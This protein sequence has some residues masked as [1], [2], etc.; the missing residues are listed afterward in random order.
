MAIL[1]KPTS[2]FSVSDRTLKYIQYSSGVVFSTFL[3]I[4]LLNTFSANLGPL[5]YDELQRLLERY[6]QN[7]FLEPFVVFGS[8]GVHI[9]S[10]VWRWFK[11]YQNEKNNLEN[12]MKIPKQNT[13]N[14][15]SLYHRYAGW[16]LMFVIGG[17]IS[18]TRLPVLWFSNWNPN[19]SYSTYTLETYPYLMYP[20]YI[21][22]ASAGFYH[23]TYGLMKM[24][25]FPNYRKFLSAPVPVKNHP[26]FWGS[27]GAGLLVCVSSVLALGGNFHYVSKFFYPV[28]RSQQRTI[29]TAL[30][31]Y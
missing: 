19:F 14:L 20:Y 6:Y 1:S 8:L 12:P 18:F 10:S 9:V 23:M 2:W 4:H 24:P 7:K 11:R 26:I 13:P 21:L 16:F 28:F 17:H 31:I 22:L 25:N 5:V 30:K 27:V 29:F 15:P 3:S